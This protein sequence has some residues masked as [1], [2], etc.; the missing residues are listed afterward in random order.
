VIPAEL[1]TTAEIEEVFEIADQ[2]LWT[3]K[4]LYHFQVEASLMIVPKKK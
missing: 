1:K 4:E 3:K 2:H